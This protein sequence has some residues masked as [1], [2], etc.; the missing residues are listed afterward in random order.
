MLNLCEKGEKDTE[1]EKNHPTGGFFD[2]L[3]RQI[4]EFNR[5]PL[6]CPPISKERKRFVFLRKRKIV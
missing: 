1:N 4:P 5:R 3:L 6:L 2:V